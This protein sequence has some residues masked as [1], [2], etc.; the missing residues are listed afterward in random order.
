MLLFCHFQR[1]TTLAGKEPP[2]FLLSFQCAQIIVRFFLYY[3]PSLL[4][5][6]PRPRPSTYSLLGANQVEVPFFPG[7]IPDSFQ[8]AAPLC[9]IFLRNPVLPLSAHLPDRLFGPRSTFSPRPLWR[10]LFYYLSPISPSPVVHC[11]P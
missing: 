8:T 5:S 4:T 3:Q 7:S 10:R 11:F 2:R 6:F 1:Y 9:L